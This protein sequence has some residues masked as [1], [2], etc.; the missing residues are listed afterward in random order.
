MIK[1]CKH[2]SI[3][4]YGFTDYE[5]GSRIVRVDHYQCNAC[6]FHFGRYGVAK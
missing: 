3:F 4:K 6:F 1:P 5:M 2:S